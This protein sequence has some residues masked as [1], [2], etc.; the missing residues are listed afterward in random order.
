MATL[1]DNTIKLIFCRLISTFPFEVVQSN[2][3]PPPPLPMY[4]ILYILD[5][6]RASDPIKNQTLPDSLPG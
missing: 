3:T 4:N 1:K 6:A 5:S 2:G